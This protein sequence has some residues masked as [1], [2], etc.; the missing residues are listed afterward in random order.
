MTALY[1]TEDDTAA[2]SAA[3]L[4]EQRP[5]LEKCAELH[6]A[7]T[8]R[9]RD[10]SWDI[11][12]HW[13]KPQLILGRSAASAA[14]V[15][16][17][18]LPYLRSKEQAQLVERL[19]GR[20]GVG[21]SATLDWRRHPIL[22][23][24]LTTDH[25]AVELVVPPSA[26]WDQRNLVGKLSLSRHRETLRSHLARMSGTFHFGFWDGIHLNE[27]LHLTNR[28]LARA[29]AFDELMSTFWDGQDWMRVG[30]WFEL[31]DPA[32]NTT[33]ILSEI[34]SRMSSLYPLYHFFLWSGN[35]NFQSFHPANA[36]V[37]PTSRDALI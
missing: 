28:Q 24:R 23:F 34:I 37:Q 26:W 4:E 13:E 11:H 27:D 6:N 21:A 20:D 1:F 9:M 18:S 17:V 22:E 33:C 31:D 8:R 16:G 7:L 10:L 3:T 12:P 29:S 2:L 14:P 25:A 15:Y 5:T 19:M 30:V 36:L 35:N 32:L